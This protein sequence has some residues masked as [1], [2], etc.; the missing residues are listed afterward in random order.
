VSHNVDDEALARAER[1]LLARQE[2]PSDALTTASA[3]LQRHDI[4][5]A[6]RLVALWA[7]GLAERELNLLADSERHLRDAIEVGRMVDD[8]RR[9]AQVSSALVAVLASRGQPDKALAL[10][11]SIVDLV[12][13]ADWADLSMKRALVFEQMGRLDDALDAYNDALMIVGAGAD[14]VLEARLRCNRAIVL[15]FRGHFDQALRDSEIAERLATDSGQ[16]LLAGGAAHNHAFAAGRRGDIVTALAS[17]ARADELYARVDYPGRCLGV[18][19]S[20]RCELMMVAGLHDEARANAE[21]A[22]RSLEDLDDVSD[23]AEARLLLARACLAQGDSEAA[24]AAA[25]NAL[26]LFKLAGREG[27]A[28]LAEY[29]VVS[30]AHR[31]PALR[32]ADVLRRADEIALH[33]DQLGW[34]AEAVAVR[35]SAA[36]MSIADGD[37]VAARTHLE[38]AARARES[39]G[40]D[41]RANAWLATAMLRRSEGNSVGA[42]RAVSAGLTM[43]AEHQATL[44][45]TDLRVGSTTHARRLVSVG[46]EMA[47]E[48]RRPRDVLVWAERVR[49]NAL[50]TPMVRPVVDSPLTPALAELR[51]LR[52]ELDETRR[53]LDADPDLEAQVSHQEMVVRDLARVER[54]SSTGPAAFSIDALRARLGDRRQLVEYVELDGA[55]AAVVVSDRRCRLVHLSDVSI[56]SSLIDATVFA[57]G[58]MARVGVSEASLQASA[59]SLADA[60]GRLDDLLVRP[61]GLRADELVIV[62]TGVLHNVAWGGLPSIRDRPVSVAASA[63]RWM[64]SSS[65]AQPSTRL[66]I[67]T[68]PGLDA[69]GREAEAVGASYRTPRQ[70]TGDDATVAAALALLQRADTAHI[71]CHGHFRADSPMFSSLILADGPLTVYDLERLSSPPSVVVLPACNAGA[72]A[73]SVGDE[74]IGTASALLGIGVRS[75][76]A[77]VTVVSDDATVAVMSHLHRRLGAGLTPSEAL[78]STRAEFASGVSPQAT[79]AATALLCLE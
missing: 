24:L 25:T 11:D 51:R 12:V 65:R 15:V 60:L 23:L 67:I 45:A 3:L 76:I 54:A 62:P 74:L 50:A 66:A 41:R 48:T 22:V 21:L 55:I 56:V 58:R 78:A 42:R 61:L 68:G 14:R 79:A 64:P 7:M 26:A 29:V 40:P 73:V 72:A 2:S 63:T 69:V 70:L 28:A 57:L 34:T 33:L 10:A 9:V 6:A 75:V 43:L 35:V 53:A 17:F 59:A 16:F 52:A 71:A 27:W 30:A 39:G 13:P 18:L 49:A 4:S 46:L 47:L 37:H 77:P 36:E 38:A 32:D 20:D 44:G 1:A 19:A 5:G 8:R 31:S